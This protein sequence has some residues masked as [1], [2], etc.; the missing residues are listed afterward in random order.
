VGKIK[1]KGGIRN[2][3]ADGAEKNQQA[4]GSGWTKRLAEKG[5]MGKERGRVGG[6]GCF[7][8]PIEKSDPAR[9][10][11]LHAPSGGTVNRPLN[12]QATLKGGGFN[13]D[14]ASISDDRNEEVG[15]KNAREG[16][17]GSGPTTLEKK[18]RSSH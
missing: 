8:T 2:S 4:T 6:E 15:E 17:K 1:G 7:F 3:G 9:A 12:H 13:R 16:G 5:V 14:C 11:P 10:V 18:K